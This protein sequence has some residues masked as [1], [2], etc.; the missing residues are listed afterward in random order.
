MIAALKTFRVSKWSL[1]LTAVPLALSRHLD[2]LALVNRPLGKPLPTP[3]YKDKVAAVLV[4]VVVV[5]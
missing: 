4:V 2:K 3:H 1:C 5:V